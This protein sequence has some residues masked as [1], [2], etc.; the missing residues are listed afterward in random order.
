MFDKSGSMLGPKWSQSTA[1]LQAFFSDPASAGLRVGLRFFPDNGCDENCDAAPCAIPKVEPAPLTDLSAP[2]DTQEQA[3]FVAFDGVN[4]GGGT[5]MST[6]LQGGLTW[7]TTYLTAH[8]FEKAAVVLVT[9]GE[10]ENCNTDVSA[11]ASLAGEAHTTYGV[12]T[13]VIGLEGSSEATINHIAQAGGSGQ[14]LFIGPNNA[15]EALVAALNQIRAST[16]ACEFVVP[17]TVDGQPVNPGLVNV[18]FTPSGGGAPV[19][20]G[21]VANSESCTPDK[22]GWYYDN[23]ASPTR[24][25]FCA[26]TC[27]AM[28]ADAGAKVDIMLG[29]ST[30]PI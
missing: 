1:A 22:G 24:L 17:A 10:P 18:V 26:S 20:I 7:A 3:L 11:I 6:A 28:Q 15:Q 19:L 27:A 16:V 8:P 9:D 2:T 25:T 12:L 30:V 13:F 5:P 14:G 29:C 23:P 4:P 21:Q